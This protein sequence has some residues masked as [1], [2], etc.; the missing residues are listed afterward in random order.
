[1][2]RSCWEKLKS[3]CE[4]EKLPKL[5]DEPVPFSP[6]EDIANYEDIAIQMKAMTLAS[7]TN[8]YK[9]NTGIPMCH[10]VLSYNSLQKTKC[11][12]VL[13]QNNLIKK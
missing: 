4:E 3:L 1:M 13:N 9:T 5:T 10:Y 11:L 6:Y 8:K 12:G 7:S 2:C